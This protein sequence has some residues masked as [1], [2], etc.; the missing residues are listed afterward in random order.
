MT[1][2][3]KIEAG[4]A[5]PP[6]VADVIEPEL[7]AVTAEI[8]AAIAKEVPGYARPL[9]GNFGRGVRT[10]VSE[11]LRQFVALIRDP[12]SGRGVGR[13]VYVE[14]GR[15][16]L[17][18]G[19]T[20]DSLQAAYRVGARVAWRRISAAG[21]R[22]N[23][24]AEVLSLLAESI[25]AYIDE[26]S[27]DSVEGYA[28]A[29]AELEDQRRR[30]ARDLA[31]LLVREP[32]AEPADLRAAAER[33]AWALPTRIAALACAKDELGRLARRLPADSL[34][35]VLEGSGC[36]LFPDPSGPGR[37]ELLER[38]AGDVTL[39]QGPEGALTDLPESWSFARTT[40]RAAQGGA[41]PAVGLQ[42][43]D[44]HLADLL[45][46]EGQALVTRIVARHLAPL[47][48]LTEKA[49]ERMRETALAY[50][51]HGGNAVEMA[52]ALHVHPQTARYRI[53]RLRELFGDQLDDPDARFELEIA[54]RH[55]V[56][57]T[58]V[59]SRGN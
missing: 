43:V 45:L 25:F 59:S 21:R 1:S 18:Q 5:L 2:S 53:A 14:L 6:A 47:D 51:R 37:A 40:L 27:A 4:R 32:P 26:L 20:L 3:L 15:G 13:G 24:D 12:E 44:D 38:I 8:L 28:E 9:E 33:A 16:E 49:R 50:V 42:R 58:A 22:A 35:T 30:R 46:F 41:V 31:A 36:I 48:E 54:L 17:R 56:V 39:T 11:A 52:A 19:R 23:L 29:Q 55:P 57:A 7:D 34:A 10:G